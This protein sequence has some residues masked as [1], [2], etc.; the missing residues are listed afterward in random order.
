M[1]PILTICTTLGALAALSLAPT[2]AYAEDIY[3]ESV[4]ATFDADDYVEYIKGLGTNH[5]VGMGIVYLP[6]SVIDFEEDAQNPPISGSGLFQVSAS[7]LPL[8]T[9]FGSVGGLELDF[10]FGF[11]VFKSYFGGIGGSAGIVMQP[12]S[13]R[14]FRAS[15]ALGAGFNA[16]GFGYAKPR[17]A[18]TLI[19]DRADMEVTYRWIPRYGSNVFGGR[20]DDLE[21]PG[22]GEHRIRGMLFI[23]VGQQP[24]GRRKITGATNV[25]V[26]FDYT[27]IDGNKDLERVRMRPGDY[28]GFGLGMA[29]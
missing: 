2:E 28:M 25:Y 26:S 14:H 24:S 22:F 6:G 27:R 5:I 23:R 8:P 12:I 3:A 9:L 21:D 13:F 18:F 19:P 7:L 16:H 20:G 17:I 15:L 4:K 11:P 1:R 10:T 29:L